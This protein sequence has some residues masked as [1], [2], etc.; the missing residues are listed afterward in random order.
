MQ[1]SK[2]PDWGK[3]LLFK[4]L[5][6][7]TE[8]RGRLP[9]RLFWP[10][11]YG[12]TRD[13]TNTVAT[14]IH[15]RPVLMNFNYA[16]PLASR[17]HPSFNNPL[18]EL[19]HQTFQERGARVRV[20]DIGAA[21]GDT[22]LLIEANCP[23]MVSEYLCVD[24][25]QEFFAYLDLN[26]A[27]L[28]R[29]RRILQ[30]LSS[31]HCQERSLVRTHGGTAS[32]LGSAHVGTV[33]LDEVVAANHVGPVDVLKIDADGFDGEILAG[34]SR[35]LKEQQPTVIFEW[36]PIL[37]AQTGN[38]CLR[39]FEALLATGYEDLV[40]FDK[41]GVFSHFGRS[42]DLR[43]IQSMANFCCHGTSRDDWHFDVVAL[44]RGSSIDR[45]TLADLKFARARRSQW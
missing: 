22:V 28:S 17:I 35:I 40:W 45:V 21:I 29:C 34:A 36:H 3:T 33:P 12:N 18:V 11:F 43:N 25:D 26:L 1:T 41:F 32:A 38:S 13:C 24:G 31:G 10:R 19:V 27:P 20:A 30:Q 14:V 42:D 15:G 5:V 8:R 16:Y 23:E 9:Y 4:L 2:K 6:H 44:P 37:C 7:A 39:H